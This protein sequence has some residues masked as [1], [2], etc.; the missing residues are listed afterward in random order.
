MAGRVLLLQTPD[1]G[2]ANDPADIE[3]TQRVNVRAVIQL[4]W[5][6]PMAAAMTRKKVNPPTVH[7]AANDGVGRVAK[8]RFDALLGRILDALHLVKS[9]AADDPD[10]RGAF[11]HSARLN[12]NLAIS[13]SFQGNGALAAVG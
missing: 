10:G 12:W 5:Q 6:E 11:S 4:V 9:A 1:R 7:L 13:A 8:R 3:R 2:D